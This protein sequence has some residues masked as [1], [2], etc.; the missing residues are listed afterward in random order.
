VLYGRGYGVARDYAKARELYEKASEKG[1]AS[2]MSGLG[3]LYA[4]GRGVKRDY[5]KA[6]EWF[7][8]AAAKGNPQGM[9]NLGVLYERGDGV[10]RDY[11]QAREWFEKAAAQGQESA[12]MALERLSI[13][14]AAT[15]G[16]YA[17]ALQRQEALAA[18][19]ETEETK[20]DD[21]LGAQTAEDLRLVSEYALSAKEFTKALTV[22]ERAH[23]LFP[24]DVEIETN[25]AHAL[26]FMGH[27][28]EAKSLYLAHKGEHVSE[29]NK[30]WEQVI[31]EDFT[32]FR[33]AG[34]TNPMMADIEKE[35]GISH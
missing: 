18:K 29:A 32:Q 23:T 21:K 20:R 30:V 12:K 1:K 11:T 3:A 6:R 34:L 26:M 14:E 35:L 22:A 27:D 17:E 5:Y 10:T 9:L 28:E 31:A 24:D 16:R 2:A 15:G 13:R 7:E 4:T 19:V 33:K 8:K 25:R